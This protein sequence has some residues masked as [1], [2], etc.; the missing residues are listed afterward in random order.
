MNAIELARHDQL[1]AHTAN[2]VAAMIHAG[3]LPP[4]AVAAT[5]AGT[6]D[7]LANL[8]S[9]KASPEPEMPMAAVSERAS[10]KPDHVTCMEC[11]QKAKMLKRHLEQAHSLTPEAYRKR[12][13]LAKDH[14][15]VAP[16][17]AARRAELAKAIG[18]GR[19][20]TANEKKEA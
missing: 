4:H 1:T 7:A 8:G 16:N 20:P 5:L 14:P 3:S 10:V 11:G 18:L 9:T 6:Y 17:Y 15:L 12:R 13:G 2:L 19:K